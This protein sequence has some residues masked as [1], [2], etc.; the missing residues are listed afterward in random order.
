MRYLNE[1]DIKSIGM[2]WED[3]I[4]AIEATV[5]CMRAHDYVQPVKPYLRY[6]NPDNRIIAMPAFV[7]GAVEAAGIKWISSFPDNHQM[8]L[9]RA[10]SVVILNEPDTGQPLAII[11]TALLSIMRTV[12]VSGFFVKG[13]MAARK[14]CKVKVGIIGLGP[15]GTHHLKFFEDIYGQWI[16]AF[17]LYDENPMKLDGLMDRDRMTITPTWEEAYIEADIVLTCTTAKRPYICLP[18][19]KGALLLNVSLRDYGSQIFDSVEHAIIVDNW[20]EVCRENTDI[21]KMHLE[22]GLKEEDTCS[23]TDLEQGIWHQWLGADH[24]IMVNPMGMASF[25]IAIGKYYLNKAIE[26]GIG[27]IL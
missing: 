22:R 10:H 14:P 15:I 25:D 9:P 27:T 11:N 24:P 3:L 12:A 18:P 21:E 16:D 6:R 5:D 1:E 19:K 13:Y 2:P 4:A 17:L 20:T 8:Q 7:G 26:K 23:I